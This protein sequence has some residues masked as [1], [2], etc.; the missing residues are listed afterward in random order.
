MRK[1]STTDTP[2]QNLQPDK[3]YLKGKLWQRWVFSVTIILMS[4]TLLFGQ[5]DHYFHHL[6]TLEGLPSNVTFAAFK[7]SKGFLWV[8]SGWGLY[9]YDGYQF[10]TFIDPGQSA[11]ILNVRMGLTEDHL[12]N[13]WIPAMSGLLQLNPKT[14]QLKI[15]GAGEAF[16]NNQR[17]APVQLVIDQ[18][19]N[20]WVGSFY[21]I[22]LFDPE[23]DFFTEFPLAPSGGPHGRK[24]SRIVEWR[25]GNRSDIWILRNDRLHRIP[26]TEKFDE[27][28]AYDLD[29]IEDYTSLL[30]V[31]SDELLFGLQVCGPE[32]IWVGSEYALYF[33]NP[34]TKD[35]RRYEYP[36]HNDTW[37][38]LQFDLDSMLWIGS[39]AGL[40]TFD[41]RT[42][43]MQQIRND[44]SNPHSI[45]D[46]A[47]IDLQMD[48]QGNLWFATND[49]GINRL[50]RH[51]YAIKH[52]PLEAIAPQAKERGRSQ[53]IKDRQQTIWM[54]TSHS[55]LFRMDSV[56]D[57]THYQHE[58]QNPQSLM[59]DFV[60]VLMEDQFGKIWTGAGTKG[61]SVFDPTVERFDHYPYPS[62]SDVF[63]LGTLNFFEDNNG[64]VF[65]YWPFRKMVF[66]RADQ[67][68]RKV[69]DFVP[70]Q[71]L[72]NV[73]E[74]PFTH[75]FEME[76][77]AHGLLWIAT[78]SALF[79]I[80]ESASQWRSFVNQNGDEASLSHIMCASIFNDHEDD[81]W[82]GTLVGLD[83]IILK[84]E[85][86]FSGEVSFKRYGTKQG[87]KGG[88]V[89]ILGE[90][91]EGNLWL[92][93]TRGLFEF[94][95][96]A[97]RFWH[98]DIGKKFDYGD[99]VWFNA[100]FQ[101]HDGEI[102]VGCTNGFLR[103]HPDSI[104]PNPIIPTVA[105][106]NFKIDNEPIDI[107]DTIG[108]RS[109]LTNDI[110]YTHALTLDWNQNDIAFEFAALGFTNLEQHEYIYRLEGLQEDWIESGTR[111]EAFFTNLDPGRYTFQVKGSNNDGIWSDDIAT[112]QITILPPPWLTWWAYTGY[113][114]AALG[115]LVFA[116]QQI[117]SRE[118]LKGQAKLEHME[119][120]KA[121]EVDTLKTQ[122]FSNISH[123]FRTPLT[124]I[125][126]PLERIR[127]M[128]SSR[129]VKEGLDVMHRNGQRLQRLINQLLDLSRLDSGRFELQPSEQELVTFLKGIWAHFEQ[130]GKDRSIGYSMT[131]D[132]EHY[133]T[134][135]D[136]DKLEKAIFNLLSNAFKFSQEGGT[137]ILDVK[138]DGDKGVEIRVSDT[139]RGIPEE[140]LTHIFDRF[141]QADATLDRKHEGSGIGLALARQFVELHEGTITVDSKEGQGST[142][143]I[144]LPLE[145]LSEAPVE[146]ELLHG[147]LVDSPTSFSTI[148]SKQHN[149][150]S[151]TATSDDRP[152][153][154]VIE[155]NPDMRQYLWN[156]LKDDYNVLEG[157]DGLHGRKL[158]FKEIPDLIVS[159]IMMPGLDGQE[160]CQQLKQDE[161][162]SHIPIILL[163]AR[164]GEKAKLEGLETG[165]DDYITKPF[166][167]EEL[168]ARV[169]NLIALRQKLREKY[170]GQFAFDPE[171]EDLSS[172]D[173]AFL[174]K[175]VDEVEAHRSD[176]AFNP[177]ILANAI[178]LSRSQLHRKLK[179]LIDM[180]TMDFV[181]CY[182]LK[183]AKRLL[184]KG[185]GNVVEVG[186][187]CG[188]NS[189]S[190]FT[191]SFKKLFGA[192]PTEFL[193]PITGGHAA[194]SP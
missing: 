70:D 93:T 167:P 75:I 82:V 132:C 137:I 144:R 32:A 142:F 30:P 89:T 126:G 60:S 33:L 123:E 76:E 8:V 49:G 127:T 19:Q 161:R 149:L 116:R 44:L 61:F 152:L 107:N 6:T 25:E 187:Q 86:P 84:G 46:D 9:R 124:L 81:L 162:T 50:D 65:N 147:M 189:P 135:F 90:D 66:D 96:K 38:F 148:G 177:D 120:E 128:V 91:A 174:R 182:R 164:A 99:G 35:V 34:A 68:D 108:S 133:W 129:E 130:A 131:T 194:K 192:P 154:L 184:E 106:T 53:V 12:G 186:Y 57:I 153:V 95:K 160:L 175:V 193:N 94:D 54:G 77:D 11:P 102:L 36:F 7:D 121:R 43:D 56:G 159:D 74:N 71:E 22:H 73:Q 143:T 112:I 37:Q 87:L 157:V 140:Q 169:K 191:S 141:Y 72:M 58:T 134:R 179:A 171:E 110:A 156:V 1:I 79:V 28:I 88:K 47:V 42:K 31:D 15:H 151:L 24:T 51:D 101:A 104:N 26:V 172:V 150:E 98:Y 23:R 168:K 40:L 83:K 27:R 180:P 190:Y 52:Y 39:R 158:A 10:K 62:S 2:T 119:L 97:E 100:G 136:R 188:F 64:N 113:T 176:S 118:R 29:L 170:S 21:N 145:E 80:D 103:F 146:N 14:G 45:T 125:L 67:P 20:Y 105:I 166:S 41:P 92:L 115:L 4:G 13:I 78:Y 59:N 122:F 173:Q 139:G 181:K 63:Y 48:D 69:T 117:I 155:D 178:G 18:F 165:A 17:V 111:N 85:D 109:I 138:T 3:H 183:Y 163:T 16:G 114:L 55:G 185:A 5:K